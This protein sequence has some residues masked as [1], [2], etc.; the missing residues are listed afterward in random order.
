MVVLYWDIQEEQEASLL[1]RVE[2]TDVDPGCFL[3]VATVTD[4][5]LVSSGLDSV[6]DHVGVH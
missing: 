2:V 4:T 5:S 3:G 6:D 1:V